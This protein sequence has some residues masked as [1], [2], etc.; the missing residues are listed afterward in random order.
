M[1][2]RVREAMQALPLPRFEEEPFMT[3]PPL[4]RRRLSIVSTAGIHR[5][6]DRPFEL[7]AADY[8]VLPGD[9]E[10]RDVVMSHVSVNYDRSGFQGDL[11]VVFPI[12]RAREL[13]ARGELG[14]VADFHYSF[15]GATDPL[16]LEE[17]AVEVAGLL[18]RD[19]VDAVLLVPV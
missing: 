11:N 19:R 10:A 2:E 6:G 16:Q 14:S 15:L 17:A 8:R 4:A 5:R 3:G 12:E 13:V 7:M 1:P 9:V 18:R